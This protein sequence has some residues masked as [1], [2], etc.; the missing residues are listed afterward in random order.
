MTGQFKGVDLIGFTGR[1]SNGEKYRDIWTNFAVGKT[2]IS[3][4][5]LLFTPD[6]LRT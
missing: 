2:G 6:Q 5:T 3:P 4:R 1:F